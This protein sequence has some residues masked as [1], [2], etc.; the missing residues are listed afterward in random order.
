LAAVS[1]IWGATFVVI[2]AALA[3]AS[4]LVFI[5]MRFVLAAV[6]LVALFGFRVRLWEWEAVR[7]GWVAG[8]LLFAGFVFQTMGLQYTTPAKSAFLTALSVVLVPLLLVVFFGRRLPGWAIAGVCAATL[9]TYYLAVPGG[10]FRIARGDALTLLCALAFA[11]HIVAV[12]HFAPRQRF[13][14]LAVWQVVVALGLSLVAVPL[15][16][17]AE[18]ETI[19]LVWSSRLLLAVLATGGLATALAFSLQ[20]WAQQFTSATHTAILYS[21]EPVFAAATSYLV[22]GERLTGRGLMG[23]G[24]ILAGVLVAELLS[25]PDVPGMPPAARPD[26][27]R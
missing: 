18:L 13:A 12:G 3:D 16:A 10:E 15:A 27:R 11:G 19:R 23:A 14:A 22:I 7:A 6:L 2:K 21:L 5:L 26:P 17:A 20:T 9:G 4:A 1:L 25:T 8:S 24:L